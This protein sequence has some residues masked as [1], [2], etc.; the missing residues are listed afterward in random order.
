MKNVLTRLSCSDWI[1][2]YHLERPF[3]L[4]T[5]KIWSPHNFC[6]WG[7]VKLKEFR[8]LCLAVAYSVRLP[9]VKMRVRTI[10]CSNMSSLRRVPNKAP[11]KVL[12]LAS[13]CI[14]RTRCHKKNIGKLI[15][16]MFFSLL[17]SC[18]ASF[19]DALTGL[20]SSNLETAGF[21]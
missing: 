10:L 5:P 8:M 18:F 4:P 7:S 14:V 13:S 19:E 12:Y 6:I 2:L 21:D 1:T 11:N 9:R 20:S 15:V 17:G 3:E 16:L